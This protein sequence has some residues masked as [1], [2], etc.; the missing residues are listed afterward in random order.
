ML[1]WCMDKHITYLSDMILYCMAVWFIHNFPCTR[2]RLQRRWV[3]HT[4]IDLPAMEWS[5]GLFWATV[6][7]T[8]EYCKLSDSCTNC[9]TP[10]SPPKCYQDLPG[11][12]DGISDKIDNTFNLKYLYLDS[13]AG[14]SA[15]KDHDYK[16][17]HKA[18]DVKS[19][20]CPTIQVLI[21]SHQKCPE[22]LQVPRR[23]DVFL[24]KAGISRGIND[25]IAKDTVKLLSLY[26]NTF[27]KCLPGK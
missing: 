1:I 3:D 15:T 23:K 19:H 6:I 18:I 14:R 25:Q 17:G 7:R 27:N 2:W 12:K 10:S 16:Q 11:Y 8:V 5:E 22:R 26:W 9:T 20:M 24:F 21:G 4:H 13:L